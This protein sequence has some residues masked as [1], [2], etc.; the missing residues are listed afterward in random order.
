MGLGKDSGVQL[1]FGQQRIFII[2]YVCACVYV[3]VHM[4]TSV[5]TSLYMCIYLC[6]CVCV[7]G[8]WWVRNSQRAES[9]KQ[10]SRERSPSD[11]PHF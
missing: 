5:C 2:V 11:S 10:V 4:Y 9:V 3:F 7:V 8:D 1:Q 6:V